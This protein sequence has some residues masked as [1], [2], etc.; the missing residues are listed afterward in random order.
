MGLSNDS[1]VGVLKKTCRMHFRF[2]VY[3]VYINQISRKLKCSLEGN[4]KLS[5]QMG[6]PFP[7]KKWVTHSLPVFLYDLLLFSTT[8]LCSLSFR[9]NESTAGHAHRQTTFLLWRKKMW[10]YIVTSFQLEHKS[11][12]CSCLYKFNKM[13]TRCNFASQ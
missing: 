9:A 7:K 2:V 6:N 11:F 10:C 13:L 12:T 3:A 8:K 1:S 4:T 5:M